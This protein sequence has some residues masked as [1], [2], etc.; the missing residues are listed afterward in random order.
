MSV[1]YL[2]TCASLFIFLFFF[3][4]FFFF[5]TFFP[6]SFWDYFLRVQKSPAKVLQDSKVNTLI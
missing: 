3:L 2:E 1:C 5:F 4:F 6:V